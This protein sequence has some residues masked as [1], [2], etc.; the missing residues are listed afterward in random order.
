MAYFLIPLVSA[1]FVFVK[2][3][4]KIF[5][6]FFVLFLVTPVI[7]EWIEK[8]KGF[9]CESNFE[10]D[11]SSLEDLKMDVKLVLFVSF[12]EISFFGFKKVSEIILSEN[13]S[14][15][16]LICASIFIPPPNRF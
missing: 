14:K 2:V 3:F 12:F 9:S 5:M 11:S 7:V 4:A 16:D 6:L 1:I 10:D 8:D 15:H 13:F